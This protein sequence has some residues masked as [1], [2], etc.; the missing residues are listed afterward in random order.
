MRLQYLATNGLPLWLPL[1]ISNQGTQAPCLLR[2]WPF[3][4]L[5][6]YMTNKINV[7]NTWNV[8]LA[9]QELPRWLVIWSVWSGFICLVLGQTTTTK[10]MRSLWQGKNIFHT[11]KRKQKGC[12][13]SARARACGTPAMRERKYLKCWFKIRISNSL[14]V[15][16]FSFNYMLRTGFQDYT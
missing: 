12:A 4:S 7:T 3:S 11:E 6:R 16:N 2:C 10:R 9:T 15:L 8:L 5:F 14:S 13:H 1:G